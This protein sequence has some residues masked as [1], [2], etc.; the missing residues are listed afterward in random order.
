[1]ATDKEQKAIKAAKA[2]REQLATTGQVDPDVAQK[3]RD[4]LQAVQDE[5]N[6]K[7]AESN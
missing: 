1:M 5:M 2:A 4:A 6:A 7:R 3:Q